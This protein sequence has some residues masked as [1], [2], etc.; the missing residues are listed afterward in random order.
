MPWEAVSVMES[1]V[2]FVRAYLAGAEPMSVLCE[3]HG[4]SRQTG[5]KWKQRF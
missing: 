2:Q 4:I 3:R 1:K 5:C